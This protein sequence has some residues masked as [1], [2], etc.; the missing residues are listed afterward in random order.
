MAY[1]AL[2]RVDSTEGVC[3]IGL[4]RNHKNDIV[5]QR[6]ANTT[7]IEIYKQYHTIIISITVQFYSVQFQSLHCFDFLSK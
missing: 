6:L 7:L 2:G 5:A 4:N 1:V 3:I